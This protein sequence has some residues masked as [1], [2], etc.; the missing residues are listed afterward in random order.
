[1]IDA[2]TIDE[3]FDMYAEALKNGFIPDQLITTDVNL[4]QFYRQFLSD[5]LGPEADQ[6]T[7]K[8]VP[9]APDSDFYHFQLSGPDDLVQKAF[10]LARAH[11]GELPTTQIRRIRPEEI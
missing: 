5:N 8:L 4:V 7:V 3:I 2:T 6:I 1:M 9:D 11:A 10:E